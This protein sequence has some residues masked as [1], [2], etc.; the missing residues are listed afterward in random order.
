MHKNKVEDNRLGG[1]TAE[2]DLGVIVNLTLNRNQ[3]CDAVVKE[4]NVILRCISLEHC[5]QFL[6][7]RFKKDVNKLGPV[8]RTATKMI[9][10]LENLTYEERV[11]DLGMFRL[12]K[13]EGAPPNTLPIR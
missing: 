13:T 9:S 6:A 1:R 7:P 10:G 8:Q 11:N 3:E 5:V 2:K 4:G 12:E